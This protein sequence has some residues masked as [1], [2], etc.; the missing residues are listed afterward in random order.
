M[1]K[2]GVA[3]GWKI[4]HSERINNLFFLTKIIVVIQITHREVCL[5]C[6][7]RGEKMR[8]IFAEKVYGKETNIS[9]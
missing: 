6:N 1:Y 4:V 7:M 8:N 3:G 2:P 5:N 9:S